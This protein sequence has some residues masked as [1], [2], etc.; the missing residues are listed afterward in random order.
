MFAQRIAPVRRRSVC[1]VVVTLLTT[2]ATPS[3]IA[4][5]EL[6]IVKEGTSMYHRVGCPSI[7]DGQNV[8]AMTRAQAESRGHTPHGDCDPANSK[9][10]K[11]ETP[12]SKSATPPPQIVHLDGTRYYHRKDCRRLDGVKDVRSEPLEQAGKSLWPCPDCRPPVRRRSAEPAV[13]GTGRRGR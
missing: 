8:L 1:L 5:S 6:V 3:T 4:Q 10:S 13:P 9:N 2:L 12:P 7:R 11:K